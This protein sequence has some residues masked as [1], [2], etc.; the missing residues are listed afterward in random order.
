MKIKDCATTLLS[1]SIFLTCLPQ[2][3]LEGIARTA[4]TAA[5]NTESS[6][7]KDQ[8]QAVQSLRQGR[9]MLRR[10]QA[11]QALGLLQTALKQFKEA[12]NSKGEAAAND[13]LGDLYVRQGQYSIALGYYTSAHEAFKAAVQQQN[14]AETIFGVP[15]N[16]Y[17]AALML[18]KA[19]DTNFRMGKTTE[20]TL[21]Y[22]QM[23]VTKPGERPVP[24]AAATMASPTPAKKPSFKDALKG[25]LIGGA[26]ATISRLPGGAI[27]QTVQASIEVYRQCIL[28]STFELGMGRLEYFN[29]NLDSS[30]QH[31]E[32]ALTVASLPISS[33]GQ[34]RRVR[35]AARTSLGD[36][37]IRQNRYDDAVKLYTDAT[38]GATKDKRLDLIWP[39][40]RGLGRARW[41]Q[42]MQERDAQK[43]AKGRED[44]IASYRDALRTIETIRQGSLRADEARSTFLTTTK[45]VYDEASGILAEMALM[46][47]PADGSALSG[48][49]LAYASEGFTI[50]EQGRARSLLE[51]LGEAGANIKEGVPPELLKRKQ[52][53]LERQQE[54]AETLNGIAPPEGEKPD[55]KKLEA[56]L[57]TLAADYD[58][59]E[60]QIRANS[61]RYSALT[62]PQPLTLS[63]VQQKVIDGKTALLEYNLGDDQSY[64]W[65]VTQGGV[66]IYKLPARAAINQQAMD[67]RAQLI[68]PKMQRRIVGVDVAAANTR[69]L[70]LSTAPMTDGAPGFANASNALYKT[71]VAPA[72]AAIGD[73]RLLVIADGA[74]NYVPFEALVTTGGGNDYASLSYLVKSHEIIYAPSAS[75]VAVVRQMN[76]RSTEKGVL[77]VADPVFN[78]SDPRAKSSAPATAAATTTAT[79]SGTTT[80]NSGGAGASGMELANALADVGGPQQPA[81]PGKGLELARLSG[82]RT[83]ATRIAQMARTSGSTPD[84]WMDL[85]ANEEAMTSRDL[86]K[87]RIVHIATHGLL[88][89]ER[90]QFTG[91]VFSL[92][93]N[94]STDGFLRSDEIFNLSFNGS[95]VMLS[96]C[97]TGLGKEK[98]GEGIIG[99][100]RAFMYAGAPTVGVSLW[101]VADQSTADLM[102]N[103]YRRLLA[104]PG[105]SPSTAMRA[106]QMD[107][108]AGKRYTAPFYWAPFVLVGDWQ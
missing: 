55:V 93:G 70:G 52:E 20:A 96:A 27:L 107:M 85:E 26:K 69:G 97:E 104:T 86:K 81:P 8:S 15:D 58:G 19:G 95:L 10:G 44:A 92:V 2:T 105:V 25:S 37:A 94:K 64:L 23:N 57:E 62:A 87:Y 77:L 61:P 31:F 28:F 54:I 16:E 42:A 108:I 83:E 56:E 35:A 1:L 11:N 89:A 3:S 72:A 53:N 43:G 41:M 51:M 68:P 71:A 17:N 14:A 59:I 78:S 65:A 106:A 73:K 46:S 22:M 75:V 50:V 36:I 74:L 91:L 45:N 82:T 80:E 98:R 84:V 21:A 100:T 88:D 99:L 32:A 90:P 33:F 6:D 13:A 4:N 7:Q 48:Q 67:L 63:E 101:S 5:A 18:A 103:F 76:K 38:K 49:S 12:K 60:N 29:N 40:Q 30:K 66:S 24:S 34:S 79:A 39:A 9:L 102:T 47:A